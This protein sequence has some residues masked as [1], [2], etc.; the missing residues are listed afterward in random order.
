M[1]CATQQTPSSHPVCGPRAA[2]AAG[3][4]PAAGVSLT[5]TLTRVYADSIGR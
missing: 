4:G 5:W 3:G 1:N 2:A